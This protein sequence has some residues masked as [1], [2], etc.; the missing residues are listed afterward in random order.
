MSIIAILITLIRYIVQIL[1]L[2]IIIDIFLSYF[3]DPFNP[4]RST[5]DRIVSPLLNPI[6]RIVPPLGMLDLS[7][8]VLL[9]LIQVVGSILISLLRNL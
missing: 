2:V 1:S 8:L 7:P 5:L 6:R 4:I 9:I 3:M